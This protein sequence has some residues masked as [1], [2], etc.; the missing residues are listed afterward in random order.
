MLNQRLSYWSRCEWWKLLRNFHL[1]DRLLKRSLSWRSNWNLW[2]TWF[3]ALN[4]IRYRLS[5]LFLWLWFWFFALLLGLSLMLEL[6]H[7][8]HSFHLCLSLL[9]SHLFFF[10]FLLFLF[11]SSELSFRGFLSWLSMLLWLLRDWTCGHF[12]CWSCLSL[13]SSFLLLH[14][15]NHVLNSSFASFWGAWTWL[16]S[17]LGL[18]FREHST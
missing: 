16:S 10:L 17:S 15:F 2:G 11:F 14:H 13:C 7:T 5:L 8:V 12:G 4:G 3:K 1:L 9:L 18:D 6:F